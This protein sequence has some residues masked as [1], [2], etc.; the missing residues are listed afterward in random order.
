MK[1]LPSFIIFA[2]FSEIFAQDI[3]DAHDRLMVND[4]FL[5]RM[6]DLDFSE[7][8]TVLIEGP[9]KSVCTGTLISDKHVLTAAHCFLGDE[10]CGNDLK[11][12]E[13][14]VGPSDYTVF[15]K[16]TCRSQGNNTCDPVDEVKGFKVAKIHVLDEFFKTCKTG[17]LAIITL[18]V[19]VYTPAKRAQFDYLRKNINK[20]NFTISGWGFD[21]KDP[22]NSGH[23]LLTAG[24]MA[25]PCP[26]A[27]KAYD[28]ICVEEST[29]DACSGDSGGGLMNGRKI[30]GVVSAGNDCEALYKA[31]KQ[32]KAGKIKKQE[33][34]QGVFTFVNAHMAFICDVIKENYCKIPKY[35]KRYEKYT[36]LG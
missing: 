31:F 9:S 7:D 36:T 18:A 15:A 12:D 3:E 21:P 26:H 10:Q 22:T 4:V 24:L 34:R 23:Q 35:A 16:G 8:I 6:A 5:P 33:T 17:D 32:S 30:M 13:T 14:E 19:P 27:Q 25:V 2:V 20:G 11:A 28:H 1:L 29:N